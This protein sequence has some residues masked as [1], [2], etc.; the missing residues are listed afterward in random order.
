MDIRDIYKK[1]IALEE[2]ATMTVTADSAEELAS[3]LGIMKNSGMPDVHAIHSEP[4][5]EPCPMCGKAMSA[6]KLGSP[7]AGKS[8]DNAPDEYMQ[9]LA[10]ITFLA[11]SGVNGPKNPGDIRVKDPRASSIEEG[12]FKDQMIELEDTLYNFAQEIQNG[13]HSYDN[14]VDELN[15]MFNNVKASEDKVLM[16]AFKVLRTLEPEDFE[17][18]EDG[19]IRASS[20]AQDAMDIISGGDDSDYPHLEGYD[21]EPEEEY[22]DD[23]YMTRDL[24][25]GINKAKKSYAAAQPGDNAIAVES[26]KDRLLAALNEKKA[27]PDAD[28]DGVPDWADKKPGKD[29]HAGKKKGSKPKKG[30]VPPQFKK[31]K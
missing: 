18:D 22:K 6:H 28:G 20:V 13:M 30:Q 11:G 16:N 14:V 10:D 24:A 3:L 12:G 27:K 1:Y 25:G 17:E 31:K 9:D 5:L 2:Q 23:K 19:H 15:D 26:I 21:N 29:D 8:W 7:C 4:E